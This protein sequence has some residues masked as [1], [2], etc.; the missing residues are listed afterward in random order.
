MGRG[1]VI[2]ISTITAPI[3]DNSCKVSFGKAVIPC[4]LCVK[5]VSDAGR[6]P[7]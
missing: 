3:T 7:N 1:A 4:A 6:K 2:E 5:N